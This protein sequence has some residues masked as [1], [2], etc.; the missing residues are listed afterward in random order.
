M[1]AS[2]AI[3]RSHANHSRDHGSIKPR[4]LAADG[5]QCSPTQQ[6][7]PTRC[8]RFRGKQACLNR[9]DLASHHSLREKRIE[10][11]K[12]S[13]CRFHSLLRSGE[14]LASSESYV[15]NNLSQDSNFICSHS[16]KGNEMLDHIEQ[17]FFPLALPVVCG[18][19]PTMSWPAEG[20]AGHRSQP[21][22]CPA[23]AGSSLS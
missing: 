21:V 6:C 14:N 13:Q 2:D 8:G 7:W 23:E 20:F 16:S 15:N 12:S 5:Q 22:R 10:K 4:R 17:N 1:I 19:A 18:A 3:L 11:Q 9:T